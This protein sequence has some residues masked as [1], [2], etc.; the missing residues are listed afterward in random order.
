MEENEIVENKAE[1]EAALP[2]SAVVAEMEPASPRA[3]R[4][5]VWLWVAGVIVLLVLVGAAYLGGRLLSPQAG[6]VSGGPGK[7]LMIMGGKGGPGGVSRS[8]KI[9]LD[10][11][12]ELPKTKSTQAGLLDHREDNSLFLGT[13]RI[14]MMMSK[15][16]ES[17]AN[18][19][20]PVVEVVVNHDTQVYRD[21]TEYNFKAAGEGKI[22]QTVKP[23]SLDEISKNMMVVV[24]GDKQG[25]RVVAKTF[26]LPLV[27]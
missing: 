12:P 27:T 17:S 19:D 13:G 14:T 23:G 22:Q 7:G 16:G 6:G 8:V 24:W 26:I 18:Y 11:A 25:D 3:G 15:D 5:K 10:P 9:D 4:K 21:T 20:G 1:I 2:G